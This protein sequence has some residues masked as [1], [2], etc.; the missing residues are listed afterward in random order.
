MFGLV[1]EVPQSETTALYIQE[2]PYGCAK[3]YAHHM[4]INYSE[5]YDIFGSS[6]IL[7]N[8][9]SPLR[10]LEFVTR[11]ITDGLAA[12]KTGQTDRILNSA[13]LTLNVIGGLRKIMSRVC[14]V[15]YRQISQIPM[16]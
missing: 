9:E 14:G 1:Q 6:G 13:I 2:V 15:Y 3:V 4:T 5:S 16:C 10:G 12:R 7:F 8:H 11:K